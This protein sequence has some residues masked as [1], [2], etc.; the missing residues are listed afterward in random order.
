MRRRSLVERRLESRRIIVCWT[1][2]RSRCYSWWRRCFECCRCC[3]W[4]RRCFESRRVTV[5]RTGSCTSCWY[6]CFAARRTLHWW[7]CRRISSWCWRRRCPWQQL[8]RRWWRRLSN[9]R[10]HK[11][12]FGRK[13]CHL[14]QSRMLNCFGRFFC[15]QARSEGECTPFGDAFRSRRR[16]GHVDG[17]M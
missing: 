8:R 2:G 15:H 13:W 4:R 9:V 3:W 6:W 16:S 7:W 5:D 17:T 10:H 14:R 11:A 1:C 12:N